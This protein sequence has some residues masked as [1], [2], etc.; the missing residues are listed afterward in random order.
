MS[1][2]LK[3]ITAAQQAAFEN[4]R[5]TDSVIQRKCDCGA[6]YET[7][8]MASVF[9]ETFHCD[10]GKRM[11]YEVPALDLRL[12]KPNIEQIM[13]AK[14]PDARF[15]TGM[16]VKEAIASACHWWNKTGRKLMKGHR[17]R[18]EKAGAPFVSDNP[19]DETFVPSG[20]LHGLPWDQLDKRAQIQVVKS[21]HHH[22]V[23]MPD[24]IGDTQSPENQ[25]QRGSIH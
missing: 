6:W 13:S 20:I 24:V 23:R 12:I 25:A 19:D 9:V 14:D 17:Q 7:R 4:S 10:C 21:W 22:H 2:K 16:T 1:D 3:P 5:I 8:R 11:S 15:D 18:Q